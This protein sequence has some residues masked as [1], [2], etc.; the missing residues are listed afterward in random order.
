METKIKTFRVVEKENG[1]VINSTSLTEE[2]FERRLERRRD[3]GFTSVSTWTVLTDV[4]ENVI[5]KTLVIVLSG[6]IDDK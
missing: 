6:G 5:D 2:E 3:T 4:T 1:E